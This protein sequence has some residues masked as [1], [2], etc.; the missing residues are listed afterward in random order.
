MKSRPFGYIF[1]CT[2]PARTARCR[3]PA[4]MRCAAVLHTRFGVQVVFVETPSRRFTA[5]DLVG[6]E[7]QAVRG[8]SRLKRARSMLQHRAVRRAPP[9]IPAGEAVQDSLL[10]GS[11]NA[12]A[13]RSGRCSPLPQGQE[14]DQG[15]ALPRGARAAA[16]F[17]TIVLPP[18]KTKDM[19]QRTRQR[20]DGTTE[21]R[22]IRSGT[23]RRMLAMSPYKLAQLLGHRSLVERTAPA[24]A[25]TPRR[26]EPARAHVTSA[27]RFLRPV[28]NI[29]SHCTR[30]RSLKRPGAAEERRQR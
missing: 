15:D 12:A 26:V 16:K 17:D 8:P 5:N 29:H 28:V 19:A 27:R 22:V 4:Q 14:H 23:V 30:P 3:A 11:L 21:R 1:R 6:V 25:S 7:A 18:Y 9:A 2:T 24:G 13:C 20:P 10:R